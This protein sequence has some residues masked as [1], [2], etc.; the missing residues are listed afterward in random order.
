MTYTIDPRSEDTDLAATRSGGV[1]TVTAD[2]QLA[3]ATIAAAIGNFIT[4]FEFGTYGYL[5]VIIGMKFFPSEN[6]VVSLMASFAT[7]GVSFLMN[8]VGGLIFGRLGDKI[9]RTKILAVVILIMSGST[10]LIGVIPTY[11]TVGILAP[12]L[13]LT[14]RL[15]Q[16]IA[17]GGEP[18]GA[19]TFLLEAAPDGKK[20][21]TVSI[22]HATSYLANASA[23][24]LILGLSA[25]LGDAL[26][27]WGWRIPFLICG[28]L[29]IIALYIRLKIGETAEFTELQ[30]AGDVSTSPVRDAVRTQGKKLLATFLCFALQGSAFF[31]VY[32]YMQSYLESTVG[33][34]TLAASMSTVICLGVAALSIF[35]FAQYSDRRG[36]RPLMLWASIC[37]AVVGFPALHFITDAPLG[38]V[39]VLHALLGA[40]V[41]MFMA[42]SGAGL[43]EIFPGKIRYTSFSISFNAAMAIFG[44][45]AP[46]LATALIDTTGSPVS[47]ALIVIGAGVL[48]T[49]GA[50][51]LPKNLGRPGWSPDEGLRTASRPAHDRL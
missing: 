36:R 29:G 41:A 34:S 35:A 39:F 47:P 15:C 14:L 44:G 20:A 38:L 42:G 33:L 8:P 28:P 10:F 26:G 13:L 7:F 6:A 12:A 1:Q 50:L 31:F 46:F 24:L 23:A 18:G 17:A 48:G 9:G 43:V 49:I 5:A 51:M 11:A 25:V 3:K 30:E 19:A 45:T 21:R 37:L 16:G 22:W 40:L 32:V 4:W 2:Q 27:E